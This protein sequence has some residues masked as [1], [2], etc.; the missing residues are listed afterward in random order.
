MARQSTFSALFKPLRINGDFEAIPF[1]GA[2]W[3]DF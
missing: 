2:P 1:F 3:H